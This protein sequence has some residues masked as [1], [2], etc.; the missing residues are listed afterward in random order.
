[1][2]IIIT[3]LL[4]V[5]RRPLLGLWHLRGWRTSRNLPDVPKMVVAAAPHTSNWDYFHALMTVWEQRRRLNVTMKESL[6]TP[7]LGWLLRAL[8]AIPVERSKSH[9][10]VE[11]TAQKIRE[12]ER[13]IMVFTPEGTRGRSEY[14]K[15]GFYYTALKAEVPIVIATVNY[16]ERCVYFEIVLTPTGDIE[17]DFEL[18]RPFQEAHGHGLFPERASPVRLKPQ[19]AVQEEAVSAIS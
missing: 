7:P 14:W 16:K 3:V 10:F 12:A 6:F 9:N 4:E 15:T 2:R 5:L 11:Q 8:G 1:M 17:A 13:M 19:A 18:I